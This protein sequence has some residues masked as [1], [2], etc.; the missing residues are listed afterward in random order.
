M[1]RDFDTNFNSKY[2]ISTPQNLSEL[3]EFLRI[4]SM[5]QLNGREIFLKKREQAATVRTGN[6][7]HEAYQATE[8]LRGGTEQSPA[9]TATVDK[10]DERELKGKHSQAIPHW[11]SVAVR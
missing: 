10:H 7:T 6:G 1:V 3:L 4:A 11:Q 9:A 8:M 2:A 5:L